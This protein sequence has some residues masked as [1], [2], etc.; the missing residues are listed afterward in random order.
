M[1]KKTLLFF[2]IGVSLMIL[3]LS[4]SS[5]SQ[6]IPSSELALDTIKSIKIGNQVWM[7]ENLNLTN[8][9]NGDTIP[10][11]KTIDEFILAC[12][13]GNPCWCYYEN[14]SKNGIIYGKIY[15]YYAVIDK[16]ILAPAGWHIP[17]D[18]EWKRT[19]DF[20]GGNKIAA[21]YM[22]SEKG[23]SKGKKS[24]NSS[25]FSALPGG[26]LNGG[27]AENNFEA[28]FTNV[29][30]YCCF[31]ASDKSSMFGKPNRCYNYDSDEVTLKSSFLNYGFYCRC[32]KD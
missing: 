2:K 29:G 19:I 32:I 10:E 1:R 28:T 31:W 30:K 20:L 5:K 9:R 6:N 24:T 21:K 3:I 11:A 14:E 12:N 16:R 13:N 27:Y 22:K 4:H 8:F 26:E 23:W 25:K 7:S 17:S 15:N 18:A